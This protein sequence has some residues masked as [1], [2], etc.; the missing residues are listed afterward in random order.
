M[1]HLGISGGGTKIAGLFGVAE[2]ILR[3]KNYSPDIISG[4][5]AGAILAVPLALGKFEEIKKIVLSLELNTFFSDVPVKENGK[6]KLFNAVS[7]LLGGKYYLG[8]QKNL[9]KILSQVVS[10]TEFTAYK[11]NPNMPV[12]IVGAVDFYTGGRVYVNLK[13]FSYE[14]FLKFVN[15][16]ASIPIFTPGISMKGN[17]NDFEGN[18]IKGKVLLF[19]GGVRDHSPTSKILKSNAF[20]ISENASIYSRPENNEILDPGKFEAKNILQIL[21][22]YVEITN[23]EISK[24][25]ETQEHF[26]VSK[27]NIANHGPFFLPKVM[28][29]VYDVSPGKLLAT[30]EAGRRIAQAF[31]PKGYDV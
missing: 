11:K 26:M 12:C 7:K 20:R 10:E 18:P 4:V 14:L 1:R 24:N 13:E 8:E 5:S 23:T 2:V 19:D 22:R 31:K 9:E 6:I 15:A 25:D 3:E 17:F 16:S 27:M 30:Y 28:D 21:N 29:G